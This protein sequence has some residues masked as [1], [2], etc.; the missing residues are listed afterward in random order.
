MVSISSSDLMREGLMPIMY[1]RGEQQKSIRALGRMGMNT[2]CGGRGC[3]GEG[4]R[5]KERREPE[6]DRVTEKERVGR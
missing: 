5:E 3:E 4:V 1:G 6:K 2:C